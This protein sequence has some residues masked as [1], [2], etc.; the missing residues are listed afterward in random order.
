M[1][2][3]KNWKGDAFQ[4][5]YLALKWLKQCFWQQKRGWFKFG[6]DLFTTKGNITKECLFPI[7]MAV[8]NQELGYLNFQDLVK[9]NSRP[10]Y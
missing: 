3:Y 4:C 5:G 10:R 1:R 2:P 8:N 7:I 9:E 6:Q